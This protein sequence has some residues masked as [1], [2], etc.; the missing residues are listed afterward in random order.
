[1]FKAENL[2]VLSDF[3]SFRNIFSSEEAPWLWLT[4][5]SEA[6]SE[7]NF[8]PYEGEV[9]K[10]FLI[11]GPVFI[12]PSVQLPAFGSI[13]GPCYIGKNTQIRPGVYIRGNVIVGDSCVLGNSC[14]FK[15][16]LILEG[17]QIPHFSYVGDSII[18]NKAHLGAGVICSNLRLDQESVKIHSLGGER[19]ETHLRK[20]GAIVG[21]YA[22]VG[23]N[24]VLNPGS[25]LLPN[26][27]VYP[28]VDFKG[29]L[30]SHTIA[31]NESKFKRIRI[32]PKH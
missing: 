12:D 1:M 24:T 16:S 29:T 2:F 23:C 28:S 17:A 6:L 21:D 26:S 27:C 10:G 22:E 18:G 30:E 11:K 3:F 13:E 4:K 31:C 9:P 20:L 7:F 32:K 5:I 14:E 8:S 25:L 19:I 15:N